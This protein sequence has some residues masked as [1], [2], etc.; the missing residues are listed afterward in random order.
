[1]PTAGPNRDLS[2]GRFTAHLISEN[3]GSSLGREAST[4]P[5]PSQQYRSLNHVPQA[6]LVLTPA[7]LPSQTFR[8]GHPIG[9]RSSFPSDTHRRPARPRGHLLQTCRVRGPAF[10]PTREGRL[11]ANDERT[12]LDGS[13]GDGFRGAFGLRGVLA[14]KPG[15]G[16][17]TILMAN[18][19]VG[20]RR[21]HEKHCTL[22]VTVGSRWWLDEVIASPLVEPDIADAVATGVQRKTG[23]G[24]GG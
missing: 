11:Q 14:A 24:G 18:R 15:A 4:F 2:D 3:V 8:D 6:L 9:D 5:K 21:L 22:D 20:R 12:A 16:C 17:L 7:P 1:M 10:G 13:P 23:N 19:L